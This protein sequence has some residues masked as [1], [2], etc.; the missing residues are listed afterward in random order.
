VVGRSGTVKGDLTADKLTITGLFEGTT[1][2]E[3][4]EI[5]AGGTL[6]GK[7]ISS[8]LTIDQNCTFE[9]ESIKKH[10]TSPAKPMLSSHK[11]Q[12][13]TAEKSKAS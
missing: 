5:L 10:A 9:G 7:V 3:N 6:K 8:H 4:V 2:C 12:P 1:D 13:V 11:I